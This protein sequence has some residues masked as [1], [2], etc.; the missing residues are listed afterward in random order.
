MVWAAAKRGGG[1]GVWAAVKGGLGGGTVAVFSWGSHNE[2]SMEASLEPAKRV[3]ASN[4]LGRHE[5]VLGTAHVG[6]VERVILHKHALKK[7]G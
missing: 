2:V 6:I 3:P 7:G 1:H 5:V 4:P